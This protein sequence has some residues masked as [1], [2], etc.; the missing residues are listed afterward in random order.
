MS[1]FLRTSGFKRIDPKEFDLNKYTSNSSKWCVLEVD[2]EYPKGLRELH[3]NYPLAPDKI[4]IEI[5]MSDYQLKV[6]DIYSIPIGNVKK[7]VSN[8]LCLNYCLTWLIKENILKFKIEA[9]KNTSCNKI[10]SISM[11]EPMC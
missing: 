9:K 2:L 6:A 1:K 3:N 10:Q 11:A 7:I 8:F 4:E 5:E